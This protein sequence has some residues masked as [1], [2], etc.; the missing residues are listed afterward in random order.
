[1]SS[2]LF[3]FRRRMRRS[4]GTRGRRGVVRRF[5]KD[6]VASTSALADAGITYKFLIVPG[7]NINGLRHAAGFTLDVITANLAIPVY[8]ALVY[9]PEGITVNGLMLNISQPAAPQSFY[10]PEQHVLC[11][12]IATAATVVHARSVGSRALSSQDTIYFLA[13]GFGPDAG[14]AF[15]CAFSISF[16]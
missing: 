11:S 6:Y 1:V 5:V 12:G 8:F 10:V 15:R 9:V 14:V 7:T 13:R 3:M 16:G 2:F 4:F